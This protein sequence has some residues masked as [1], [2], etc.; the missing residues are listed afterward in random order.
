VF[1]ARVP[2]VGVLAKNVASCGKPLWG[3]NSARDVFRKL[4]R[5]PPIVFLIVGS[6]SVSQ[7]AF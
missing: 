3:Y 1:S 2:A 7:K 6:E 4:V 5:S